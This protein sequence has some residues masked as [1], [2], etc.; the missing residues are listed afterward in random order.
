MSCCPLP[1]PRQQPH[2]QCS[3]KKTLEN[4]GLLH[5]A[6]GGQ[7]FQRRQA[8]AIPEVEVKPQ[9]TRFVAPSHP[10]EPEKKGLFNAYLRALDKKPM[11]TKIITSGVICGIGDI[12]AQALMFTQASGAVTLGKFVRSVELQR[13]SIYTFLGAFW[14]APFVHYWFDT[15]ESITKSPEGPPRTFV[16]RMGKALKMVTLDQSIGAPLVNAG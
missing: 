10:A 13:F 4:T 7:L 12:M 11:R 16:G 6:R 5:R 2:T 1:A 15:L 9:E 14:I 8:V 3:L